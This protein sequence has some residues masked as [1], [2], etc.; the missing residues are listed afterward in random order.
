MSGTIEVHHPA[1]SDTV[2]ARGFLAPWDID[3]VS[4]PTLS[5]LLFSLEVEALA[6][7]PQTQLGGLG[8]AVSFL[9][10]VWRKAPAA[11]DNFGAF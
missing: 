2:A 11:N 7:A 8:S 9:I 4:A 5:F 10:G 6:V 1:H 3:H